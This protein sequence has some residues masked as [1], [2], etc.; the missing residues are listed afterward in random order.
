MDKKER[1][2]NYLNGTEKTIFTVTGMSA[3]HPREKPYYRATFGWFDNESDAVLTVLEN[4]C[5]IHECCYKWM[6]VE[7]VPTGIYRV[8]LREAWFVWDSKKRQFVSIKKPKEI[9]NVCGFSM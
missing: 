8:P 7:E 4:D 6:V 3:L 2:N 9:K 5:D 1:K